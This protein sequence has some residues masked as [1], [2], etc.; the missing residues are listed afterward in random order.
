M[1]LLLIDHNDSFTYNIVEVLRHFTNCEITVTTYNNIDLNSIKNFDKIILSPGPGQPKDYPNTL[2]IIRDF[3]KTKPLLGICLGH[4]AIC[5]EFGSDLYNMNDVTH[6]IDKEIKIT[7]SSKLFNAIPE[8]TTVGLYH[9]WAVDSKKL[10]TKISITA[11]TKDNTIMS[12]SHKDYPLFG[13]QFHPESFLTT[14][15][16]KMLENFINL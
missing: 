12:V 1:K 10:S 13:I 7:D 14:D 4:Q 3:Y 15:G 9:S 2:K 16:I 8:N 6:G 11:T 5:V